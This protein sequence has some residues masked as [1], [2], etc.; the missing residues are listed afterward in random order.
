MGENFYLD[1]EDL[2]YYVERGIAW[3]PLVELTERW[4]SD[5]D[6]FTSAAE[7]VESYRE[8]LELVG[9][10]VANEIAPH[11]SSLDREHPYKDGEQVVHPPVLE[12]IFQG[13]RGLGLHGQC[14]PRE[15]DGMNFPLLT[16][17]FNAEMIA[18]ADVSVMTHYSFH[19]GIAMALLVYSIHEG[20]TAF[21]PKTWKM[22][23]TRFEQAIRDIVH[24]ED[25]GSMDIT[26]PDAGSDMGALRT[27]AE[28][29]E[30]GQWF[31]TGQKIFITSGHGRYHVVIARTEPHVEGADGLAGLSLFLVSAWEDVDGE[32][33]VYATV[34]RLEEK[35]GHHASATCAVSFERSP[36]QLIGERGQ[37]F[38]QMLL[39]M[40]NARVGVG[41]EGLGVMEAAWRL[42]RAYAAERRAFGK[43]IDQHEMI[44]ELLDGMQ[45][46]VQ[47]V[48]A[49][50]VHA[51]WHEEMTHKIDI[52]LRC[53]PDMPELERRRLER[54]LSRCKAVSR[55][56]TPL[57]KYL[58]SE[59]AVALARQG[60]Q[61][62]GGV[63][64]TQ[65]YGAEKLLRD[66]LVLPV[67][68][69]TSQIQA[70]MAMKDTL[71]GI[72]KAP[73]EFLRRLAEAK[74]RSVSARDPLARGVARVQYLSL[75]AQQ[76][77]V[78]RT[79]REKWRS[80]REQPMGSWAGAL[81]QSWDPKRDFAFAMLHAERLIQLLAD[82]AV[83]EI[84]LAQAEQHP[85]RA[86][87]LE[88]WLE[89][90]EPRARHL[91]DVI[92]TTG[93]RLLGRLHGEH[94]AAAAE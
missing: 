6:G 80:V 45:T 35:M 11:W 25:W 30:D 62:H 17:M 85:E 70:L 83:C 10:Y 2:R 76:H 41:F 49:M 90:A 82:E 14:L 79:A 13:L 58:S 78:T 7:A 91:Y 55:R 20:S 64:Y 31:V 73:Q 36:A 88:R 12:G 72:I 15:L 59:R 18:R 94:G 71:G 75:A 84:L 54:E 5:T 61:I 9:E 48:R 1:N 65:E 44:A 34:D 26:E 37:G 24:G 32:R 52:A 3:G 29:D 60:M 4:Y 63:G 51:A 89:R 92:T 19:G 42:A 67:Y 53:R 69:G 56:I 21:D 8:V 57:L 38:R 74:V 81:R 28:Q 47:A 46:D 68:E 39:L 93:D 40:N 22:K 66:A 86:E 33:R 27:K 77:L 50:A 16:Y 23:H 87:V 43:A